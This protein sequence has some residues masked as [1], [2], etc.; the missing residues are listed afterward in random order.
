MVPCCA[1]ARRMKDCVLLL[2]LAITMTPRLNRVRSSN[3]LAAVEMPITLL[4]N[5]IATMSA[6]K[7]RF[8]VFWQ[9]QADKAIQIP[10][11]G[12]HRVLSLALACYKC[13]HFA[14]WT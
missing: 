3:T 9:S 5:P 11:T 14:F 7:V 1:I 13:M 6:E 10:L 2:Y 8:F 12:V 4:L